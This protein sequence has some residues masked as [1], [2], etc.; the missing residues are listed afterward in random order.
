MFKKIKSRF[1]EKSGLAVFA[2]LTA[3]SKRIS[4]MLVFYDRLRQ[5]QSRASTKPHAQK[6]RGTK[7]NPPGSTEKTQHNLYTIL[8]ETAS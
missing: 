1:A 4:I 8:S 2:H 3:R 7:E 5:T 6:Q